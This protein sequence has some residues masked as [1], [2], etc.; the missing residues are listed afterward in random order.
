MSG[1]VGDRRPNHVKRPA[2]SRGTPEVLDQEPVYTLQ[3]RLLCVHAR[4]YSP[5]GSPIQ[6]PCS[7]GVGFLPV[8]SE[9]TSTISSILN[10]YLGLIE[11]SSR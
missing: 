7:P 10:L 2:S 8:A 9:P 11:S 1:W 5:I 4:L 6:D 3:L